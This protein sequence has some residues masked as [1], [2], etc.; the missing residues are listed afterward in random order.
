MYYDSENDINLYNCNNFEIEYLKKFN[1][2]KVTGTIFL[3]Q[4][5][6]KITKKTVI[7]EKTFK[8]NLFYVNLIINENNS[9]TI[10]L[11]D[12][13]FQTVE[14]FAFTF[15]KQQNER[16]FELLFNNFK[17]NIENY[18]NLYHSPKKNSFN[19]CVVS[20]LNE[21]LKPTKTNLKLVLTPSFLFLDKS[22]KIRTFD[23]SVND[24]FLVVPNQ[25][26]GKLLI[27]PQIYFLK[28][29][30]RKDR[31]RFKL[32]WRY[33]KPKAK[34]KNNDEFNITHDD[35][36]HHNDNKKKKKKDRYKDVDKNIQTFKKIEFVQ[37]NGDFLKKGYLG[38]SLNG[39]LLVKQKNVKLVKYKILDVKLNNFKMNDLGIKI[40][41]SKK[42][43][44]YTILP[45]TEERKTFISKFKLI[46][47][48]MK[49]KMNR[50]KSNSSRASKKKEVLLSQSISD[51][52]PDPDQG[53]DS[54]SSSN[55]DQSS[56]SG[57]SS[58]SGSG[59][60]SD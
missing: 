52:D 23:Y 39:V 37:K 27:G 57:S 17:F 14:S 50:S 34:K 28:F 10:N 29:P 25:N 40:S 33:Y 32:F 1:E 5:Y 48:Q 11:T 31:T 2:E 46:S 22:N 41:I 43:P 6:I 53:S 4:E 30:S 42:E 15:V 54:D 49:K 38:L 36:D 3:N 56:N 20:L 59:S 58:S 13:R 12:K 7:D 8:K 9:H 21:K 55:D 35:D 19:R 18:E 26:I 47:L 60:D 44:I 51:S 16:K 24:D 45:S